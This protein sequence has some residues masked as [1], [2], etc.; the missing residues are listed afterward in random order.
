MTDYGKRLLPQLVDDLASQEPD[1]IVYSLARS[2]DISQ[3]FR[4]VTAREFAQAVDK[5]AWWLHSR[6]DVS[7]AIQTVGYIGPR[8]FLDGI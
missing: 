2:S 3:G 7:T 1:R 5:T 4:H 8:K 6:I